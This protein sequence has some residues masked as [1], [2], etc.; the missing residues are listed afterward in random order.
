MLRKLIVVVGNVAV[1]VAFVALFAIMGALKPQPERQTPTQDL[2][3]VFV[4]T[5]EYGEQNLKVYAQGEVQ[6]KQQINLT[7]QVG[8]RIT[9]V[10]DEFAEGGVF[11]K[12]EKLVQIED[13]DYRLAVTRAKAEVATALQALEI[14]RAE[15][16]LAKQDYLELSKSGLE[17]DTPSALTLRGPQLARA[18]ANYQASLANLEDAELAL[19]RTQ[20]R[21]PFT[22]RVRSINAN[23]G[24]FVSPGSSLGTVFSTDVVEIRL[25][26]TDEDLGRLGIPLAFN[27]KKNGP[28]VALSTVV[29]GKQRSWTGRIVRVD[30]AIDATTRQIAAIAEVQDPYGKAAEEGGFPIAVGLYVDAIVAGPTVDRAAVIPRAA[31]RSD[32]SV[33]IVDDEDKLVQVPVTIVATT[34]IGVI[35]SDGLEEGDRLVVSRVMDP[36]GTVVRPLD[37]IV[38]S[39]TRSDEPPEMPSLEAAAIE[40]QTLPGTGSKSDAEAR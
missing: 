22:G 33:F 38:S 14:E 8:G 39:S 9:W 40:G 3:V 36:E 12:G 20:I 32:N 27:D 25:P 26:L 28:E 1:I 19:S 13:A 5:V 15:S 18:E 29:A 17:R 11:T 6:P 37:P 21:V 35:V 31:L 16:A 24:Q 34:S 10:S 30:A 2:S 4:Q 7:P 23:L